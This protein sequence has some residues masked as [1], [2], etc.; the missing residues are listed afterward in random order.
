MLALLAVALSVSSG[1]LSQQDAGEVG[2]RSLRVI[3]EMA[4][5]ADPEIRAL[6]AAAWGP[7][8][9]KAAIRSLR[10][11][12]KD[13]HP[14]VRIEAAFGL[15][16]LGD[17]RGYEVLEAIILVS[18]P[19]KARVSSSTKTALSEAPSEEA[20]EI[21][22]NKIRALAVE[23]L[24]EMGGVKAVE[25]LER[26][27]EDPVDLVRDA[28]AVALARLG[29]DELDPV[30]IE[31]LQNPRDS[32]RAATARAL[33][34]I[35]RPIGIVELRDAASDKSPAVRAEVLRT[36]GTFSDFGN[37]EIFLK[38]IKDE[39]RLVQAAAVEAMGKLRMD[40]SKRV[41]AD[42]A[43]STGSAVLALKAMSSLSRR[44]EKVDLSLAERALL[45]KD[46]DLLVDAMA[47]LKVSRD[48]SATHLLLGVLNSDHDPK[49]RLE[50][51]ASLV[52]RLQRPKSP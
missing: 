42:L 2:R 43:V 52:N 37:F 26:S 3:S 7:I 15:N 49:V 34:M 23:R 12:L 1:P 48:D 22:R 20:R 44:G 18:S 8:G 24:G 40:A 21:V 32:V 16:Q 13:A 6:A 38:G 46:A 10:G 51:A 31:T 33:G 9:N 41:L 27:V 36:L 25:I 5:H 28:S 30:F 11:A 17:D 45:Q 47:L 39:N 29:F 14:V 50:A 35:G 4:S 19:T